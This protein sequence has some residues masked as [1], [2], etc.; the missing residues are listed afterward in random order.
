MKYQQMRISHKQLFNLPV[1]TEDNTS[2][3]Y[4]V[5]LDIHTDNHTITAYYVSKHKLA[6]E[7]FS[8]LVGDN[9]LQISPNQVVTITSEHMIVQSTAIPTAAV[10]VATASAQL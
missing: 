10:E 7:L 3:G 6:N 8:A 4:V 9:S 5:G 2:L 1:Y